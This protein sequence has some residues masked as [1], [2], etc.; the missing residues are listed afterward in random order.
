MST[1]AENIKQLPAWDKNYQA[2]Q[3]S[4]VYLDELPYAE[5]WRFRDNSIL[6]HDYY[7]NTFT[8]EVSGNL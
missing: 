4:I 1:I 5:A 3:Q 8:T 7:S 2:D 6:R